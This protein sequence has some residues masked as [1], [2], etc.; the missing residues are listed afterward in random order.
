MN[1]GRNDFF[2][3]HASH[4]F[5]QVSVPTGSH[6]Q[7][8]WENS[9]PFPEGMS[10]NGIFANDQR[11]AEAVLRCQVHGAIQFLA[12]DVQNGARNT[13]VD[14]RQVVIAGV[15]H[16]DLPNLFF[17]GHATEQVFHALFHA[18]RW[19]KICGFLF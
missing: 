4:L 15:Q 1:S 19:I 17:K 9:R 12:E 6:R 2:S 5:E 10:M 13:G 14:E 16:H 11:N 3:G 18:Q 7:L 8:S